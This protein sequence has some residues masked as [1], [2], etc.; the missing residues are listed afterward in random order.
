[1]RKGTDTY[2]MTLSERRA[3]AVVR[4]LADKGINVSKLESR[5]FGKSK[6]R[7]SDPFDAANRRVETRFGRQLIL[8]PAE[9]TRRRG[10]P[11]GGSVMALIDFGMLTKPVSEA[12][13]CGPD[14]DFDGDLDFMNYL[15]RAEGLL[16]AS[17]SSRA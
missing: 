2:N 5:G 17:S 1:M 3:A 11:F 9:A 12:A 7:A 16:P 6:P 14:L 4:Y 8:G 10:S 15:A 13:P